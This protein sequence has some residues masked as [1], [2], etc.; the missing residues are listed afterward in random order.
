[1]LRFL[2]T[3]CCRNIA[4]KWKSAYSS[5][6]G[7][8]RL[9]TR[10]K[11]HS[12]RESLYREQYSVQALSC[13]TYLC[14]SSMGFHYSKIYG[15]TYLLKEQNQSKSEQC[16]PFSALFFSSV[17]KARNKYSCNLILFGAAVTITAKLIKIL[18]HDLHPVNLLYYMIMATVS[19]L[20]FQL[21]LNAIQLKLRRLIH[22]TLVYSRQKHL[23]RFIF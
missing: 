7:V 18:K 13:M 15:C 1:M 8:H 6:L 4:V 23:H 19:F 21:I 16:P 11:R 17:L 9:K 20:I 14:Q 3:N 2:L 22:L 10:K 12:M 5:A